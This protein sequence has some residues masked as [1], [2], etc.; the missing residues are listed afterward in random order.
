[1][2]LWSS[3]IVINDSMKPEMCIYKIKNGNKEYLKKNK[4]HLKPMQMIY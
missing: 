2:K 4:K 1:M 3:D